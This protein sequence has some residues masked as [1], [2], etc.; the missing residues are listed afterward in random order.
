MIIYN[1]LDLTGASTPT[2]PIAEVAINFSDSDLF[3]TTKQPLLRS[4]GS[5]FDTDVIISV[6]I[7]EGYSE[8][9]FVPLG[10][11]DISTNKVTWS[12]RG[13]PKRGGFP[14]SEVAANVS[15]L[16]IEGES[17]VVA[18]S[19]IIFQQFQDGLTGVIEVDI[20][21]RVRPAYGAT[22]SGANPVFADAT[23]RDAAL[24]SPQEGD[25]CK[26][27]AL[28]DQSYNGVSWDTFGIS[29]P[30]TASNGVIKVVNDFQ[31]DI[32]AT[33]DLQKITGTELDT[34]LTATKAQLDEAG[35]FFGVSTMTGAQSNELKDGAKTVLHLH[36]Q[37][38][39]L[40]AQ[41][42]AFTAVPNVTTNMYT[43]TIPGGTMG[44]NDRIVLTMS[45]VITTGGN[46]VDLIFKFNGV[47]YGSFTVSNASNGAVSEIFTVQNIGSTSSQL[48]THEMIASLSSRTF[49]DRE[50]NTA[51]IDTTSDV[52]ISVDID[53]TATGGNSN[54]YNPFT[55][56]IIRATT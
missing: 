19:G 43:F 2:V 46:S 51:A 40:D 48:I 7:S 17:V 20:L 29:T 35:T 56:D 49:I 13:L 50:S 34:N 53:W 4:D 32:A 55:V 5:E 42:T 6:V 44:I 39:Q 3:F 37:T 30:Q 14:L 54:S 31:L 21:H 16:H 9:F 27:T 11:I 24:T 25:L 12:I 28:G 47:T 1:K 15:A 22:A 33:N 23:A 8:E 41:T 38:G 26:V 52:D 10:G 18:N 36:D 45:G